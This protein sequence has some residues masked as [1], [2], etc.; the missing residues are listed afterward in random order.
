LLC[1][2]RSNAAAGA[3]GLLIWEAARIACAR[4]IAFDLDG[5]TS[6]STLLFLSGFGGRMVQRLRVRRHTSRFRIAKGLRL[7]NW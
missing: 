3:T 7:V 2:R 5:I 6:P 4:G 1:T